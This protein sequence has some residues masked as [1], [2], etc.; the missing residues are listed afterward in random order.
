MNLFI[1]EY[2]EYKLQAT[3]LIYSYQDKYKYEL[4]KETRY[5]NQPDIK[6]IP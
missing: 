1:H 3:N 4:V 2:H 6:T 5:V